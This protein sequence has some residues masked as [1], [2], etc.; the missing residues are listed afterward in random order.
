MENT[1][2]FTDE[3]TQQL[4][5]KLQGRNHLFV[6][7]LRQIMEIDLNTLDPEQTDRALTKC[8]KTAIEALK[9]ASI[10]YSLNPNKQ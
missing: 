4:V 1:T 10:Y 5:E 6:K 3:K 7:A 9:Q 8:G 2:L